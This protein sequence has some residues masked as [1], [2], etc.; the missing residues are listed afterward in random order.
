MWIELEIALSSGDTYL[1]HREIDEREEA[2]NFLSRR[3]RSENTDPVQLQPIENGTPGPG[4]VFINTAHIA[5]VNWT[6]VA[7]PPTSAALRYKLMM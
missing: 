2:I 4:G 6:L 3:F 5:R 1:A 7:A